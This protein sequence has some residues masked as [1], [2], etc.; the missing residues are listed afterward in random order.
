MEVAEPWKNLVR[1]ARRRAGASAG[2]GR[3]RRAAELADKA[4]QIAAQAELGNEQL[5][6]QSWLLLLDFADYLATHLPRG[7]GLRR[8]PRARRLAD[9]ERRAALFDWLDSDDDAA[10]RGVARPSATVEHHAA[11]CAQARSR[12]RHAPG[13]K[14]RPTSIA[15]RPGERPGLARLHVPAGRRARRTARATAPTGCMSRWPIRD[16]RRPTRPTSR[17]WRP[18]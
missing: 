4:G 12:G 10:E 15:T 13:S 8:Q 14:A 6:G 18:A 7:L 16:G 9:A 17:P 3:Q 1:T 2:H 11:R 5:Q